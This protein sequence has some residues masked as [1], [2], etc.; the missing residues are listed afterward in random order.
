MTSK[1][2]DTKTKKVCIFSPGSVKVSSWGKWV[3]LVEFINEIGVSRDWILSWGKILDEQG[4]NLAS[5]EGL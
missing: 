1:Q 3:V 2:K 4:L 5:S